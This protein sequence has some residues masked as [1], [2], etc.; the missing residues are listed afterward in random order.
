MVTNFSTL[1]SA[2]GMG[3]LLLTQL[4]GGDMCYNSY[5][6]VRL[7]QFLSRLTIFAVAVLLLTGVSAFSSARGLNEESLAATHLIYRGSTLG[8]NQYLHTN[9]YIASPSRAF[10]LVLQG[11]G[12][13]VEY[14]S[15]GQPLWASNT[16]GNPGDF[17]VMQGD[18]NLVVYSSNNHPLW[19][20]GTGNHAAASYYL[21]IQNDS[22]VVIYGPTGALWSRMGG[23]VG[24]SA[25]YLAYPWANAPLVSQPNLDWGYTNC[26]TSDPNCFGHGQTYQGHGLSDPWGYDLRN[27]TSYVAWF[28]VDQRHISAQ[29]ITGLGNASSW[30]PNAKA[31]G[32]TTIQGTTRGVQV[33]DVAWWGSSPGDPYGHVAIVT[34][35]NANGSVN[36]A[37]FNQSYNGTFSEQSNQYPD[38]YIVF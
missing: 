9:D 30:L 33:G 35:V 6:R 38:G 20:S 34:S 2:S 29:Q 16:Q 24:N 12:N 23:I 22:N 28:E 1:E 31:R 25:N 10:F 21:A 26:P 18:G 7:Q 27:C 5:Q 14:R 32:I 36:V 4:I 13:L 19:A 11:D 15:S 17:A 37:E 3:V 8:T